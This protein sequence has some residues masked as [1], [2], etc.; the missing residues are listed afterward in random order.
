MTATIFDTDLPSRIGIYIDFINVRAK[1]MYGVG[2]LSEVRY[3]QVFHDTSRWRSGCAPL[4]EATAAIGM[5]ML[6]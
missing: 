4:T 3:E 1:R 6:I 2:G 5:K